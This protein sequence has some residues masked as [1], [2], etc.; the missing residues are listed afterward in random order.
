MV[1]NDV[2]FNADLSNIL[3]KLRY[4]LA[5]RSILLFQD[6][7]KE[8]GNNI[9]V[10]CPYHKGGQESKPSAGFL[11]TNGT[12][13]CFSCGE[14][15]SLP[16]VISNC[17]GYDDG[18]VYGWK[19]LLKNFVSIEV[20]E[21]GDVVLDYSRDNNI[22]MDSTNYVSEEE[23]DSYRYIHPYMY[24]RKLT[25]EIIEKFDIGYDKNTECITFPV[26]DI[27]GRTLFIA[28]RSVNYKFF[29]YPEGVEKPL[30][31][32]YE[33]IKYSIP[34]PDEVEPKVLDSGILSFEWQ[35]FNVF[36]NE[37]IVCESMLDALTC[38]VYGKYAVAM[39]G[40][41]TE[42]QFKQLR[43]LPQRKLILATDSDEAGMKA[44]KRIKE[45][46]KNK[47]ITEYIL[48]KG[49]KDINELSKEEFDNL[50]E[51]M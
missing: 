46:V 13:H 43:E 27:N 34:Y 45:N 24:K 5:I 11:K 39:N 1:I 25:D 42:L 30:Y 44:R 16:E 6:G 21:R 23:L 10:Q 9:M 2:I 3:S 48:P 17:F 40:L 20:E 29:N 47:I 18:G 26:R 4:D 37:V 22:H 12:F 49:R 41:G 8:S 19:W 38:W 14:T 50:K 35:G 32:L 7:F 28:R 33:L 31:G 36:P 15:H 51:V